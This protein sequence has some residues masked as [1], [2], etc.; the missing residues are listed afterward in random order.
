[1]NEQYMKDPIDE[2]LIA[3][4][5]E[6]QGKKLHNVAKDGLDLGEG[7]KVKEYEKQLEEK[8]KPLTDWIKELLKDRVEKAQVSR[9]LTDS[10]VAVVAQGWGWTGSTE[11]M[12]KAQALSDS[13]ENMLSDFYASAK[14]IFEVNPYHPIIKNLLNRVNAVKGDF[15]E[16]V[17]L[18]E[19][20][21]VLYET[22][23]L[24]SGYGVKNLKVFATRIEKVVRQNLGIKLDEGIEHEVLPSELDEIEG[25]VEEEKDNANAKQKEEEKED[26]ED[27]VADGNDHDE[28]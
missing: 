27:D 16:L 28:L 23:M 12:M 21:D 26:E 3:V 2:Y 6:Y 8:F 10:P 22:A 20:M 24:K 14:K 15:I 13:T 4:L 19:V 9:R 25:A 17:P 18:I 11:R 5:T 1:M 7:D